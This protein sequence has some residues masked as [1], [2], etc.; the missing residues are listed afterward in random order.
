[1]R[2]CGLRNYLPPGVE[3]LLAEGKDPLADRSDRCKSYKNISMLIPQEA[4]CLRL[5]NKI[6]Y[7]QVYVNVV[8]GH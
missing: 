1:M 6:Y 7:L 2:N 5:S 8:G 3:E 4:C